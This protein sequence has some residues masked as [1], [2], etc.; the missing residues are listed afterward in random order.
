M[1][2]EHLIL[3]FLLS[4]SPFVNAGI[5]PA[6][7]FPS[8]KNPYNSG[9][10]GFQQGLMLGEEIKSAKE[11]KELRLRERAYRAEL[12]KIYDNPE[13]LTKKNLS[14]LM[15][16]YPEFNQTTLQI[17]SALSESKVIAD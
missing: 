2:F 13:T 12:K 3:V 11:K 5:D 10:D 4:L 14:L 1:K 6:Y 15:L 8:Q 9:M 7:L 17:I 16:N